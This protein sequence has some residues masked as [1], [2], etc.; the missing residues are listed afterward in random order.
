MHFCINQYHSE[1][2][3]R[4]ENYF[5]VD[6]NRSCY[7]GYLDSLQQWRNQPGQM[8]TVTNLQMDLQWVKKS[9]PMFEHFSVLSE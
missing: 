2:G 3:E 9:V 5:V 6:E 8:Q 7:E 1:T 4:K